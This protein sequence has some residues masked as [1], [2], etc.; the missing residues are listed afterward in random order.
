[1]KKG[2]TSGNWI[3]IVNVLHLLS[4][5]QFKVQVKTKFTINRPL[6][7]YTGKVVPM[8]NLIYRTRKHKIRRSN[9]SRD[10]MSEWFVSDALWN[11]KK[12]NQ[13]FRLEKKLPT[14]CSSFFLEVEMWI[15]YDLWMNDNERPH[16]KLLDKLYLLLSNKWYLGI[17]SNKMV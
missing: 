8:R 5:D 4:K 11:C 9:Q 16:H 3:L 12:Y 6:A 10:Q 13:K 17:E 15:C 14:V 7:N 2:H 1:M